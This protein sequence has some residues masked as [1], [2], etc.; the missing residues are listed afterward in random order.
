MTIH[1]CNTF[2]SVS[3][4]FHNYAF[5][6]EHKLQ[7]MKQAYSFFT[8]YAYTITHIMTDMWFLKTVHR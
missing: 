7:T 6:D 3:A 2:Y 8:L 1:H 4:K 5:I